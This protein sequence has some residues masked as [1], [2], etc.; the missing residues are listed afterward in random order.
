VLAGWSFQAFWIQAL[1]VKFGI[2]DRP[3][4]RLARCA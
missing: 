3:N 1:N 2:R 4:M